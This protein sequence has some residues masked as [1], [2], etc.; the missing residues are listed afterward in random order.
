[1]E[2]VKLNWDSLYVANIP[3]MLQ[4]KDRNECSRILQRMAAQL[5]NGHTFVFSSGSWQAAVPI[6]TV[7]I[8]DRV[9]VDEVQSSFLSKQGI[10]RGIQGR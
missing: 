3:L 8:G 4:A 2:R 1:M 7:L 5:G 9:Y 10:R 6:S